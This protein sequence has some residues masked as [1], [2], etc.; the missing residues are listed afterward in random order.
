MSNAVDNRVVNM[1]FNNRQFESGVK[2]TIDSLGALKKGLQLEESAKSLTNL[3]NVGRAFSLAGIAEGVQNISNK[4]SSLG[5]IGVTTLANLTNAAVNF[6]KQLL[7]NLTGIN[8]I[9]GGF[10]EYETQIGATQTILANTSLKGTT[11][12]QVNDALAKLNEYSDKTIYNFTE[13]TRN[14]GTFTA[15][16]VDLDTSVAAI[17][18]IANLAA[19]S[20]STSQQASTAMY[21]LSQALSSG[22]VKLMDWNSVVNAGMGGQIFQDALKETARLHGVA[23]DE[24]IA[25]EGS[26][27]DTL[28]KGWLTSEVLT[29][30][31]AKFTGDLSAQQLK[32]MGYTEDQIEQIVKLGVM[33]N[34]AATK[35]KTFSQL[36]ETLMEAIGSGWAQTWAIVLGDFEEAKA[37]FTELSDIF[38]GL[39]GEASAAR[40]ETLKEWKDLGG[41]TA[42]LGGIKNVLLGFVNLTAPIREAF[43]EIFPPAAGMALAKISYAIWAMTEPLKNIGKHADK[44]KTIFKGLFAIFDIVGTL[45]GKAFGAL[46][47]VFTRL[48][49]SV[50]ISGGGIV[51]FLVNIANSILKFR[52]GIKYGDLLGKAFERLRNFLLPLAFAAGEFVKRLAP[53]F[54]TVKKFFSNVISRIDFGFF[55]KLKASLNNFFSNIDFSSFGKFKETLLDAFSKIDFSGIEKFFS[56]LKIGIVTKFSEAISN[57]KENLSGISKFFKGLGDGISNFFS[58]FGKGTETPGEGIGDKIKKSFENID[59]KAIALL[60]TGGLIGAVV[61]SVKKYIDKVSGLVENF[62][63]IF[64]GVKGIFGGVTGVLDGV[65]GSLQAWQTEL[66]AKVIL[67]IA[68]SI[69]ILAASLIAL[70]LVDKEKLSNALS[71]MTIMFVELMASLNS[72]SGK[73]GGANLTKIAAN[74]LIIAGALLVLSVA[75]LLLSA[76]D[77][78]K[79]SKG[80]IAIGVALLELSVFMNSLK[81][82]KFDPRSLSGLIGLAGALIVLSLAVKI[83]GDMDPQK[84]TQGLLGVGA[85]LLELAVF[86]TATDFSSFGPK[87]SIGLLI[88]AGA[89]L[90]LYSAV[91]LFGNL[92]ITKMQQGLLGVGILLGELALFV[93][94]A[95]GGSKLISTAIALTIIS[96]SLNLLASVISRLGGMKT[97]ELV[98]G[99][100][101]VAGA[102]L[103]LAVATNVM[104]GS[105]MGAVAIMI[106]AGAVAL[107][108]PS[109]QTLGSLDLKTIGIALLALA[110]IFLVFGLAGLLLTPLVPTLLLLGVSIM[111]F[112]FAGFLAGAGLLA[113]ALGLTSLIALG[114]ANIATLSEVF[115]GIGKA[116]ADGIISFAKTIA[117]G[118]PVLATAAIALVRAL[119]A[120]LLVLVPE[121]VAAALTLVMELLKQLNA[122]LPDILQAGF[123]LI[124]TLLQGIED[125]IESVVTT[126]IDVVIAFIDAVADKLPDIIESGY[127]LILSFITGLATS[128]E[129]NYEEINDA[130]LRLAKAI[131]KGLADGLSNGVGEV[132]KAIGKLAGAAIDAL[133]TLL[134]IFS[135]STVTTEMGEFLGMGLVK[136]LIKIADKVYKAAVSMGKEAVSGIDSATKLIGDTFNNNLDLNPTIRPVV[137][138]SDVI[139]GREA[140]N[141]LFTKTGIDVIPSFDKALKA[142][143]VPSSLADASKQDLLKEA[144][145]ISFTQYNYSPEALSRLEIY[146]QTR[147]LLANLK[148]SMG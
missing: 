124:M 145:P 128:I 43:R 85:V 127:Q 24:M 23:I 107:L 126:A 21:Q 133:K 144:S 37:F 87:K 81:A 78:V 38:G 14:I 130:V 36:K 76:I 100:A 17:K 3:S 97:E 15:A 57:L 84:L 25:S 129:D 27:R 105:I 147:N 135:P 4:F 45:I 42:L 62:S 72:F 71:V 20:G 91:S 137:D 146:R 44:I 94:V 102:L 121:F 63:G 26:F 77:P 141:G 60:L 64:G 122:S 114:A 46:T 139:S 83:F 8:S 34:D 98:Q 118:A 95:S 99:L 143:L 41:R 49:G 96:V 61:L 48:F 109:I 69:A 115:T 18:G 7:V 75:M 110:G 106:L 67:T 86:M 19:V 123:D 112:G 29:E 12:E 40:N 111:M 9:L 70:S 119:I 120:A 103:I 113:F 104:K 32:T 22:T 59:W 142:S 148:G 131:I 53:V 89:L 134:G 73:A 92:D 82:T 1:G 35:V 117:E 13:M 31:L 136:G 10:R 101:G 68:I 74:L 79:L 56:S 116:L 80:L 93:R 2:Q 132:M 55:G 5:V 66:K 11:L 6:G 140:I 90:V 39:I 33:A 16:G 30:T 54:E 88:M 50:K 138:L 51:D 65:K 47:G 58:G 52:D 28:Q 125:N 108:V